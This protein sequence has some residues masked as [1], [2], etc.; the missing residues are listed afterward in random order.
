VS[1]SASF[2]A[3]VLE[4]MQSFGS[5]KLQ[6][7]FGGA[8]VKRDGLTLALLDNDTLYLK[9]DEHNLQSFLAEDLAEFVYQTKNGPMTIKGYRRAPERL[10]DDAD[11]MADWCRASFDVAMRAAAGKRPK[12]ARKPRKR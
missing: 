10:L 11:E 6:P 4:Q 3:L 8:A 9:V 12:P 5:V 7:M 2:K 1:L